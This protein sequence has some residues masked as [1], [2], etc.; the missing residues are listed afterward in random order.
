MQYY[1]RIQLKDGRMCV[2]RHAEP[3]DAEAFL[4]Y[5]RTAHGETE[6]LT[7]YPDEAMHSAEEMAEKFAAKIDSPKDIEIC[8]FVD[9]VLVG[10]AGNTIVSTREKVRHRA[11]FGISIV[12]D[13][14]G[15]GIGSALT[16]A[17]IACA[18]Q[19]GFVQLELDVVAD[20]TWAIA[21]YEKYG[22]T[23]YGRN[24]LGFR[25]REGK[26]QELSYMRLVL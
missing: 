13:Y 12:R 24:P 6:Y 26:W 16:S 14:W 21:L 2:L 5:F 15:L 11:E 20:N 18:R 10:S 9:G 25:T 8:A 3:T 4:A 22:F 23:E 1:E 19:A 17:A 7:T